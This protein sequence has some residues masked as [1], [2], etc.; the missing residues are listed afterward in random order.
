MNRTAVCE[1]KCSGN[2]DDDADDCDAA[3]FADVAAEFVS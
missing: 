1:S 3:A 2:D